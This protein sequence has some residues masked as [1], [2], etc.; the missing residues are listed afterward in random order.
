MS[1]DIYIPKSEKKILSIDGELP[2]MGV[3]GWYRFVLKNR[4][5]SIARDTGWFKNVITNNGMARIVNISSSMSWYIYLAIGNGS[6]TPDVTD[7]AMFGSQLGDR[8]TPTTSTSGWGAAN[9]YYYRRYTHRWVEGEG[10]GTISEV[11]TWSS[12]SGG[13]MFSHA[14]LVDSGGSPTTIVKGADQSL[15]VYYELRNYP[16]ASDATGTFDLSGTSYDYTFRALGIGQTGSNLN[17]SVNNREIFT[18]GS[19]NFVAYTGGTL[20]ARTDTVPTGSVLTPTLSSDGS[21]LA[22]TGPYA[23]GSYYTDNQL[24]AGI[25]AWHGTVTVVRMESGNSQ[26]QCLYDKTV[27]GGGIVK[28]D[29]DRLRLKVR[30]TVV[31]H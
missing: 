29:E 18:G 25:D 23:N 28:T 10:T 12:N 20:G 14:L 6:G 9:A 13:T 26:Y 15:D 22:N 17:H 16:M 19:S 2:E 27:G 1:F 24:Q 7:T 3:S 4:D 21:H 5:G 8:E 30:L 31:R 11:S